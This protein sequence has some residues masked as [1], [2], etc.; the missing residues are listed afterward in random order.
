MQKTKKRIIA[1]ALLV[2]TLMLTL[3]VGVGTME[4]SAATV[5]TPVRTTY[6]NYTYD[7]ST[8]SGYPSSY[9]KVTMHGASTSGVN[10]MYNDERTNWSYYYIKVVDVDIRKHVSFKLYRNNYLYS[11]KTLSDTGDLTLYSGT[12]PDGEYRLE[13]VCNIGS[14][15]S[16]KDYTYTYRFEVDK[17]S[18]SATL[19]AGGSTISS[20]SYTNKQVVYSATD[21][22]TVRIRLKSPGATSYSTTYNSSYTVAATAA[23]NGWW[24]MYAMDSLDNSAS[25]VSFY[26]DTVAPVGKVTNSSGT[27]ISNGGYTNKAV[28]YTA[29]D[30]GGVSYL[31]VKT[32]GS[33]SWSSYTSGT[34][35]SSSYGW[36]TFRAVDKA[37]NIST[38]YKVYY[39]AGV[40]TGTLYGGTTTKSSGSYT[41]ASYVKYTASDSY[42]GIANIYVKMPNS[43]YYTAY[44]SG[45][46]L[47]TQGTYYFYCVDKSGN[48]SST[49]SITL[50][51]SKPT[52]TLYG[53]TSVISSGGSTN[54]SYIKFVPSDNIGLQTTYVKK[55]GSTSYAVYTSGTQFTAEGTYSFYSIDKAGNTSSTYTITL[56]RQ[57]PT[58]QLYVDGKP[59]DNN[60]YTNGDHI[61][62]VCAENCFVK[63]PDSTS[64]VEYLSGAEYYKPGRY[65]FYGLD[66]A[67]NSTGYFT[68]TIDRTVKTVDL[69]NVKDGKTNGDVKIT[70]TNGDASL[71]A[72]IKS[73][74]VNGKSYTKG[75]IIHTIDTGVY[76]VIVT[77]YAGN[78]WNTTFSST[79]KNIVTDTLQKE[80]YE[81]FDAD[82]EY[83]A[84]ST[85]ENALAFATARENI[86]VRKGEWKS[87]SWDAGIAMDTIDAANAVNGEYFI[88]KKSGNPDEWVAYFTEDRLNEVIAEYAKVGIESYYYWEK[89][90]ATI[91]DGEN[92][93][94]YS[95]SKNILANSVTLG[96][97]I[98]A[99]ID[100]EVIVDTVIETEGKHLLIV[101]DDWGNNCEYNLTIVRVTPDI[102]YVVGEGSDNTVTFDR[103]YYFKD[104]VTVSIS[105]GFDEMAMFSVYD[106]NG[107]LLGHFSLGETFTLTKSGTYTV[108]SVNHAGVSEEF[109][110]IISR[111]AP[112]VEITENAEDKQLIIEIIK[113][114]DDESHIQTLEIYKSTDGGET[115]VLVE[116]DDYGTVVSLENLVYKFRTTGIY[117]ATITDEF[118]TGIDAV[119]A[120]LDYVQENPVGTLN[121]VENN[122]HTN[123]KVT[124]EWDDEAIVTL[125][126]DGAVIEYESGDELTEDGVYTLTFENFD[127]YKVSYTFTID[128]ATPE[129]KTDGAN[130]RESVNQD[131]K[132]F[133]TEENLTAELFKDGKSLGEYVSGNP[134]SADGQYRV[135]V[136]D[137]AGNEVS[138]EFTIDKTVDYEI[139]VYDKGLSNSVVVTANE[140]VTVAL[141][142]NGNK[143]DYTLGS[144]I[145]EPADYVLVITD[146]LNNRAE[147]SFKI[148]EPVVKAF[149]HNFDEIEGL[150]G[151]TVNGNDHRLNYGTLELK[152]DGVYEVG[153]I[154]SGKTYTFKVT[155]DTLAN[156]TANVHNG[157]LA[158]SVTIKTDENVTVTVTKNGIPYD[159]TVGKEITEP[160]KYTVK[161]SDAVGNT[162]E[163]SFTIV[164]PVVNKF[165]QEIDN[166]AAY[167]KVLVNGKEA[168]LDRGS[169]ILTESGAYEV[170]VIANGVTRSFKVTV[171][172]DV[173]YSANVHNGGY[174]NTVKISGNESLTV[175]ATKN[176]EAFAYELGAEI[177][178][179]A[180]YAIK[181]TDS[182]GNSTEIAFTVIESVVGKFEKEIKVDGVEKVLVN[183]AEI[184]IDAGVIS[185]T[186]SGTYEVSVI[187]G[188]KTETFAVTVDATAPSVTL[189]GVENGGETKDA[190]II[191][192][193]SEN[194]DVKVAKD[195]EEIAYNLGDEITEPG[196]YKVTVTDEIGNT[197]EYNF[198]IKAGLNG[199]IIALIVI[200]SLL[201][202]GGVVVFILKKKEVI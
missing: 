148:V 37:G 45:T 70:W 189:N 66:S 168:T 187:A 49:V 6:G 133:Y 132:V 41:N 160:A 105:D 90:P 157:G 165:D 186:E 46:Q 124:F 47:A 117:K 123:G 7:G 196:E 92:L 74:T 162:S 75:E 35:L 190:V 100:G 98:G 30:T 99:S 183:G 108:E 72:P 82:G 195:G 11:S 109:E 137:Q 48:Q 175:S 178:E 191:G 102:H 69:S 40:P 33:S 106:E 144:A 129:I 193:L 155:V 122:G 94:T 136:S 164:N 153:V 158:N 172:S 93:F 176:G 131:V 135:R 104:Q 120:Q 111:N 21:T 154:V 34:S 68:I 25:T 194:A 179:P 173:S 24:Y 39:D 150:G 116:K 130:H 115:W 27:T 71:Y 202:V 126:K 91:A 13:Y 58:A 177:T 15:I 103:V 23:N 10:T 86:F 60:S 26:L 199:G 81:I 78:T 31:Q 127:G 95:D 52:G 200:V 51:T 170:A 38:E 121:G 114:I 77:D 184:A 16:N 167:E 197:A 61:K 149:S 14:W 79:K 44:S 192:D 188:G 145:T 67:N 83:F 63:L 18:P 198:T 159:Y 182:L 163:F 139:N 2:L 180:T 125:T 166:V 19:K 42:S 118:R 147:I 96:D 88:Y 201:V 128:T 54:A 36:Y 53:G 156:Y 65:V 101:S 22:N 169:L 3:F 140:Q 97:N 17:T 56:D 87:E 84:F 171:D 85:Y 113:S 174:A 151:V 119:T 9:F 134:I 138:V 73:V 59:I 110:L 55:P 146:A 181:L 32:P 89:T 12:L 107:D 43:S 50:D 20:G 142:K 62:F 1:S 112:K 29:T 76:K 4:A 64:F 185:L 28:K 152:D 143:V 8:Y 5:T 161:V 80:Y 57:I 141:T